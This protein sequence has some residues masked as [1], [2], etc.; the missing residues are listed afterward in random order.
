MAASIKSQTPNQ[1]TKAFIEKIV[2]NANV[3]QSYSKNNCVLVGSK[4]KYS[5]DHSACT[6]KE[7]ISMKNLTYFISPRSSSEQIFKNIKNMASL[8]KNNTVLSPKPLLNNSNSINKDASQDKENFFLKY[9]KETNENNKK[10][11]VCEKNTNTEEQ[12]KGKNTT[13]IIESLE[14]LKNRYKTL[15]EMNFLKSNKNTE[16]ICPSKFSKVALNP[17]LKTRAQAVSNEEIVK[18]MTQNRE[19][20][21]NNTLD[22]NSK[23]SNGTRK[24]NSGNMSNILSTNSNSES[25]IQQKSNEKEI[26]NGELHSIKEKTN[27]TEVF[28][29][30]MAIYKLNKDCVKK[31]FQ[32]LAQKTPFN[33][34]FPRN[35]SIPENNLHPLDIKKHPSRRNSFHCETEKKQEIKTPSASENLMNILNRTKK[36]V[37]CYK[38]KEKMWRDEKQELHSQIEELKKRLSQYEIL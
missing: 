11:D 10:K 16:M 18:N 15:K 20:S 34:I 35:L 19:N 8:A 13:E 31:I 6:N 4:K 26:K 12:K 23:K 36:M 7:N 9:L 37:C 32:N 38:M 33:Q 22:E 2:A 14:S 24:N 29:K 1:T 3:V 17:A 30:N 25:E 5:L 27:L 28:Q 21:T